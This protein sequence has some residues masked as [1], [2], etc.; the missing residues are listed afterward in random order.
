MRWSGIWRTFGPAAERK[1]AGHKW[2]LS[3]V[4]QGDWQADAFLR[5]G[6][7]PLLTY[8]RAASFPILPVDSPF[9]HLMLL[10]VVDRNSDGQSCDG[11]RDLQLKPIYDPGSVMGCRRP[12]LDYASIPPVEGNFGLTAR[13]RK[14]DPHHR[15]LFQ[16]GFSRNAFSAATQVQKSD[17]APQ[18]LSQTSMS[19]PW[20]GKRLNQCN[21]P[22]HAF[23]PA[24][25]LLD[26]F[27]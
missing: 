6:R 9:R 7:G 17:C 20:P 24:L 3:P 27:R 22:N 25:T 18:R 14:E 26:N 13:Q 8:Q 19:S 1:E 16:M 15:R 11:R 21:C 2:Y 4:R 23:T 5:Y 10:S 12:G